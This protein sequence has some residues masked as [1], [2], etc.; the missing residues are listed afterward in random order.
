M[1]KL[2]IVFILASLFSCAVNH[3]ITNSGTAWQHK[4]QQIPGRVECEYYNTGGE[5]LPITI[6]TASI[7]AVVN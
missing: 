3:E 6:P 2:L 7:M 1:R 4:I 5:G